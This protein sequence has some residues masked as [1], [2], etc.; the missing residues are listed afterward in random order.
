VPLLVERLGA[1]VRVVPIG[2]GAS[3]VEVHAS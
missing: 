1:Q 2:G 3:R